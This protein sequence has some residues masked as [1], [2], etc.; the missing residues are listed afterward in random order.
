MDR[1]EENKK[2]KQEQIVAVIKQNPLE[3]YLHE[4][5]CKS[6][7][8]NSLIYIPDPQIA[9]TIIASFLTLCSNFTC[10]ITIL[11]DEKN[12]CKYDNLKNDYNIAIHNIILFLEKKIE[13]LNTDFIIIDDLQNYDFID[14]ADLLFRKLQDKVN[15]LVITTSPFVFYNNHK[16]KEKNFFGCFTPIINDNLF[17]GYYKNLIENSNLIPFESISVLKNVLEKHNNYIDTLNS[18]EQENKKIYE[19]LANFGVLNKK[20]LVKY[21]KQDIKNIDTFTFSSNKIIILIKIL[22]I[23]KN[24]NNCILVNHNITKDALKV[25][26]DT[27]EDYFNKFVRENCVINAN[28]CIKT[29]DEF[30]AMSNS[31]FDNF[32]LFEFSPITTNIQKY[33]FCGLEEKKLFKKLLSIEELIETEIKPNLDVDVNLKTISYEEETESIENIIDSASLEGQNE[34]KEH[35]VIF[36]LYMEDNIYEVIKSKLL[37]IIEKIYCKENIVYLTLKTSDFSLTAFLLSR[38]FNVPVNFPNTVKYAFNYCNF[39]NFSVG[40]LNYFDS[41]ILE[42]DFDGNGHLFLGYKKITLVLFSR[43]INIKIEVDICQLEKHFFVDFIN[44]DL[45]MYMTLT[46]QPKIFLLQENDIK[47]IEEVR[48]LE[49]NKKLNLINEFDWSRVGIN[50]VPFFKNSYDIR[51]SVNMKNLK[52]KNNKKKI[53]NDQTNNFLKSICYD[54]QTGILNDCKNKTDGKNKINDEKNETILSFFREVE[55]FTNNKIPINKSSN[56]RNQVANAIITNNLRSDRFC[57]YTYIAQSIMNKIGQY[58]TNVCFS[59]ISINKSTGLT[60]DKIRQGLCNLDFEDYYYIEILLTKKARYIANKLLDLSIFDNANI[61]SLV[62]FLDLNLKNRFISIEKTLEKYKIFLINGNKYNKSKDVI[63]TVTITP[64]TV[65]CQYPQKIMFNRVLRNFD[66]EHFIKVSFKDEDSG[67]LKKGDKHDSSYVYDNIKRYMKDGIIIGPKRYF[68]LAMSSSQ[69]KL[70]CAWF[71]APYFFENIIIGADYIRSWLGDFRLIKNIGKY[72]IRLGQALSSTI[73]TFKVD[74]IIEEEDVERNGYCFT[75]GIGRIDINV[76]KEILKYLK[77][78][79]LPS[80]FQI[81]IGGCKGVISVYKTPVKDKD[82][83]SINHMVKTSGTYNEDKD[84]EITQK[85]NYNKNLHFLHVE[86]K[87]NYNETCSSGEISIEDYPNKHE[88]SDDSNEFNKA[89]TIKKINKNNTVKIHTIKSRKNKSLQDTTQK[90]NIKDDENVKKLRLEKNQISQSSDL[91]RSKETK[92][93]KKHLSIV[94]RKS[95]KKYESTHKMLEIITFSQYIP[96]FLN[97]QII[98][99]LESLGIS[100]E[101][102][103]NLHDDYISNLFFNDPLEVVKKYCSDFNFKYFDSSE[104]FF[105]NLIDPVIKRNTTDLVKKS[106][107]FVCKSRV[108]MGILDEYNVLE[109]NEVF[110]NCSPCIDCICGEIYCK[111][112]VGNIAVAKNPCLHPGDIRVVKGVNRK[113]L[114]Y[115][116]NVIVFS[117]KGSRPIFNMCSGSD[118]DG[119]CYFCTWDERLVPNKTVE[120]DD[121]ASNTALYKEIVSMDDIINFYLKFIRENQLGL[122]A[123][124]HLAI[125]DSLRNGVAEPESIRLARLFN[126]GVDFPKTG[127]V[128]RLPVDLQ[129]VMYPDFME[130]GSTYESEKVLGKMFRRSSMLNQIDFLNCECLGFPTSYLKIVHDFKCS[131]GYNI[132]NENKILAKLYGNDLKSKDTG[133]RVE[134]KIAKNNKKKKEVV[135]IDESFETDDHRGQDV[136]NLQNFNAYS[137]NSD[138]KA[139]NKNNY[140]IDKQLSLGYKCNK[141]DITN[142]CTVLDMNQALEINLKTKLYETEARAHFKLYKMEMKTFLYKY[143]FQTEAE[144]FLG[145]INDDEAD[146]GFSHI[147]RELVKRFKNIFNRNIKNDHKLYKA[148]AWYKISNEECIENFLSF[149]WINKDIINKNYKEFMLFKSLYQINDHENGMDMH[150]SNYFSFE[151]KEN[152]DKKNLNQKENITQQEKNGIEESFKNFENSLDE[153]KPLIKNEH[154]INQINF[155]FNRDLNHKKLENVINLDLCNKNNQSNTQRNIKNVNIKSQNHKLKS[156]KTLINNKVKFTEFKLSSKII[157]SDNKDAIKFLSKGFYKKVYVSEEI[158]IIIDIEAFYL[159]FHTN[160]NDSENIKEIFKILFAMRYFELNNFESYFVL[161]EFLSEIENNIQN[162]QETKFYLSKTLLEL[163]QIRYKKFSGNIKIIEYLKSIKD[164]DLEKKSNMLLAA[165][166]I[167]NS[168]HKTGLKLLATENLYFK[169]K[170]KTQNT[171][172]QNEMIYK[173]KNVGLNMHGQFDYTD[174]VFLSNYTGECFSIH[175]NI[176]KYIPVLL[177]PG[178][179]SV[180]SYKDDL[181]FFLLNNAGWGNKRN[182]NI[183]VKIMR[184]KLYFYDINNSY[185]NNNIEIREMTK[186]IVFTEHKHKKNYNNRNDFDYK[187]NV[188]RQ[189]SGTNL[190]NNNNNYFSNSISYY[191]NMHYYNRDQNK[192]TNYNN[193]NPNY[194]NNMNNYRHNDTKNNYRTHGNNEYPDNYAKNI[195]YH[196]EKEIPSFFINSHGLANEDLEAYIEKENLELHKKDT[197]YEFN[198]KKEKTRYTIYLDEKNTK[199]IPIRITRSRNVCGKYF[200][201][202]KNDAYFEM[203]KEEI[204]YC[205][206]ERIHDMS[207]EEDSFL[208]IILYKVKN[209]HTNEYEYKIKNQMNRYTD[210]RLEIISMCGLKRKN[211]QKNNLINLC[212]RKI[213]RFNENNDKLEF[214]LTKMNCE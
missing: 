57:L 54:E 203:I 128:A 206:K 58:N 143:N 163:S 188:N 33:I 136:V 52:G 89:K 104:N 209:N 184:G 48:L 133:S 3:P 88:L 150:L 93:S 198:F 14:K 106:K 212:I 193:V 11:A 51:I 66:N 81:R 36:K 144:A 154:L 84:L 135:N 25:I 70:H 125:S 59:K 189:I 8:S 152:I 39:S 121:Y 155:S 53:K 76:A 85:M 180:E 29:F 23:L 1:N 186:K 91:H 131:N 173:K 26:F 73:E 166:Y 205:Y 17:V 179:C 141:K 174:S 151:K 112:I 122:I 196:N 86:D 6:L 38:V 117:T 65:Q 24:R 20:T 139:I 130:Q 56:T 142:P 115:L 201:I 83:S 114:Q 191:K 210:F 21:I 60:I 182:T 31:S 13:Q 134:A 92:S 67:L 28:I 149:G 156:I 107:I 168:N 177:N 97:R 105:L 109:E 160:I 137:F 16:K 185:I 5:F 44:D 147:L 99:L 72:A 50:E 176:K 183:T 148:F 19:L 195:H 87:E 145:F 2:S 123:N 172:E 165:L 30:Y 113:E 40:H 79:Q 129:P 45:I 111:I 34:I 158:I 169:T 35:D 100:K 200:I 62:S 181:R 103:L 47:R 90:I 157:F 27:K 175:R 4:V 146:K 49:S 138:I 68:F 101:T 170:I 98:L 9:F 192:N 55:N 15:F 82:G 126:L 80:A 207:R 110:I 124:A 7:F 204:I 199:L 41:F 75:D 178:T 162:T 12:I 171:Y 64:L 37:Q 69:L 46:Y 214:D 159:Q 102:F 127:F 164:F 167:Y 94:I 213:F 77:L 120:P 78:K 42:K 74:E 190:T 197:F 71:V 22:N 140:I 208:D 194:N 43:Q 61:S 10:K 116:T 95:M 187:N 96:G 202:N 161:L 32:I 108:L 132:R 153:Q 118:L 119:D 211:L 63:K 18:L